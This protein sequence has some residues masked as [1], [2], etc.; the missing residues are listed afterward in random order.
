[1]S[2]V[3]HVVRVECLER[4][5]QGQGVRPI[6][7]G[8][9]QTGCVPPAAMTRQHTDAVQIHMMIRPSLSTHQMQQTGDLVDPSGGMLGDEGRHVGRGPWWILVDRGSLEPHRH[10]DERVTTCVD[11]SL[12]EGAHH[13]LG[14]EL[15]MHFEELDRIGEQPPA[16]RLVEHRP[17]QRLGRFLYP[18]GADGDDVHRCNIRSKGDAS[19]GLSLPTPGTLP[20]AAC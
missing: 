3:R 9:Q 5:G 2:V 15:L 16:E 8:L 14:E 6:E 1:M 11:T 7:S 4:T 19:I 12:L 10:S 18:T 20:P 13:R 17:G